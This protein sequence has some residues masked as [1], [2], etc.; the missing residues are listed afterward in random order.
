MPILPEMPGWALDGTV[1]KA[2]LSED[3]ET[4]AELKKRP[5]AIRS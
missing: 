5:W 3:V 4:F 2:E 1:F